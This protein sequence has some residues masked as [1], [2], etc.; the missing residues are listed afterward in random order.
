MGETRTL[1]ERLAAMMPQLKLF[2]VLV[3]GASVRMDLKWF[4][5]LL[6]DHVNYFA[7]KVKCVE[8][9]RP[10]SLKAWPAVQ[11][12]GI[13]RQHRFVSRSVALRTF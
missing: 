4:V 3:G 12:L 11:L 13:E 9:R 5:Q 10:P 2:L 8:L 1:V 6:D 7:V